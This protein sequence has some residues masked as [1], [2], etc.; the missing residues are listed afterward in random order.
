[1]SGRPPKYKT[2]EEMQKIIDKYF[3]GCFAERT[4]DETGK[5]YMVTL[6]PPTVS[7]LAYELGMTRQQLVDYSSKD[8]FTDTIKNAKQRI[9]AYA[10]ENLVTARNPAGQIFSLK[11]NYGWVDKQ[12]INV[13]VKHVSFVGEDQIPD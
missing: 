11:N 12:D 10:E 7:G 1:M 4:D 13:D 5:L 2:P 8:A 3:E 6:R 9:Q